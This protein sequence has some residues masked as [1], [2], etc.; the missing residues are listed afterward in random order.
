M[1]GVAVERS[2]LRSCSV[3]SCPPHPCWQAVAIAAA[4]TA[5]C[6]GTTTTAPARQPGPPDRSTRSSRHFRPIQ[7]QL[8]PARA[9][10]CWCGA[11]RLSRRVATRP[12]QAPAS[13]GGGDARRLQRATACRFQASQ[14]GTTGSNDLAAAPLSGNG[15]SPS[16]PCN[17]TRR[18]VSALRPCFAIRSAASRTMASASCIT[19]RCL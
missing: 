6:I 1:A 2:P 4:I 9:D 12:C 11:L 13:R 5:T 19:L 17:T 10:W 8:I 15:W 16:M 3:R 7:S 18:A 14:L